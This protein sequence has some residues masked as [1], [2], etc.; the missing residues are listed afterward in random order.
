MR[1]FAI[2]RGHHGWHHSGLHLGCLLRLHAGLLNRSCFSELLIW[3]K[4]ASVSLHC[5]SVQLHRVPRARSV[6]EVVPTRY[7]SL[8]GAEYQRCQGDDAIAEPCRWA[9]FR[10]AKFRWAKCQWAKC[11]W[12]KCLCTKRGVHH[13]SLAL[14]GLGLLVNNARRRTIQKRGICL[15]IVWHATSQAEDGHRPA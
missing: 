1:I 9:K 14:Q 12:A 15:I 2:D 7:H 4:H 13:H 8:A 3:R 5:I 11:Q 6:T 10:W